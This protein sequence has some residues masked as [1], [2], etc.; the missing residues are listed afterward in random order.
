MNT[1]RNFPPRDAARAPSPVKRGAWCAP[2]RS[3]FILHPSSLPPAR[4]RG[5]S[6]IELLGVLTIIALL[7]AMALVSAQQQ[8][9]LATRKA[10]S[11]S[12]DSLAD[13]LTNRVKASLS[14]PS[15]ADWQPYLA[16]RLAISVAD[17]SVNRMGNT[18]VILADPTMDLGAPGAATALPYQQSVIGSRKPKNVRFVVISSLT[19]PVPASIVSNIF[20]ITTFNNLWNSTEGAKPVSWPNTWKGDAEDIQIRRVD[21]TGLFHRVVLYNLDTE[22]EAQ[23]TL[24]GADFNGSL[25]V[26]QHRTA[27]RAWDWLDRWGGGAVA[28]FA[29]SYGGRDFG[30]FVGGHL[31]RE[32]LRA[33]QRSLFPQ[34]T[35]GAVS[36]RTR[37]HSSR[38]SRCT[39]T[40]T[41]TPL[42]TASDNPDAYQP[43]AIEMWV[44]EGTGLSLLDT[45]GNLAV[46]EIIRHDASY[47]F[48]DGRWQWHLSQ[49]LNSN[50]VNP[51]DDLSTGE[52]AQLVDAFLAAPGSY[53]SKYAVV[54]NLFLWFR[55]A[56]FWGTEANYADGG[57][58]QFWW[59]RIND[60]RQLIQNG[61]QPLP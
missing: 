58:S 10:E 42:E 18:R 38:I 49:G 7:S 60:Y 41:G 32:L 4:R 6:A 29:G 27:P 13:G 23:W 1:S 55:E 16:E 15:P 56:R 52:L 31:F 19:D 40:T 26:V 43:K 59:D 61:A 57:N 54:E 48:E 44:L 33:G 2:R 53:S 5:F 9:K 12:L 20:P 37:T 21:L 25:D 34:W 35:A 30:N 24:E 45:S 22:N 36:C 39:Q 11:Q 50:N 28:G 17:A 14:I 51:E 47:V 3:S 46:R 8:I